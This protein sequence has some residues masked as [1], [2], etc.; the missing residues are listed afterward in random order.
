MAVSVCA[1]LFYAVICFCF[2]LL[3]GGSGM[4]EQIHMLLYV[5]IFTVNYLSFAALL[6]LFVK[7]S[8]LSIIIFLAYIMLEAG[9][10]AYINMKFNTKIGNLMPLQSSDELLPLRSLDKIKSLVNQGS[11]ASD[12]PIFVYILASLAFIALYYYL[13][14]RKMLQSDL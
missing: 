4:F 8:G 6:T 9:I 7:R 2:G 12:I 11:S 10:G 5:F 13:A 1:S 3:S 14:R